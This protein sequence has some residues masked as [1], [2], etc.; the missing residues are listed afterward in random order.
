[1]MIIDYCSGAD[2]TSIENDW[3]VKKIS[4]AVFYPVGLEIK[5]FFGKGRQYILPRT[6]FH[7]FLMVMCSPHKLLA[8]F[9]DA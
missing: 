5:T 6:I 4:P 8:S 2:F 3:C 9:T 7:P 1:M